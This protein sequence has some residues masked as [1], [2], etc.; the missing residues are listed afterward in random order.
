MLWLKKKKIATSY[1]TCEDCKWFRPYHHADRLEL[2]KCANPLAQ[3]NG[4]HAFVAHKPHRDALAYCSNA[5]D[6]D[7]QCG[8]R[9]KYFEPKPPV[10]PTPPSPPYLSVLQNIDCTLLR[11]ARVIE[12]PPKQPQKRKR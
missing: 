1:P 6:F 4:G 11:I 12:Q 10:V 5:R 9:G 7:H 3:T 8:K 2:S